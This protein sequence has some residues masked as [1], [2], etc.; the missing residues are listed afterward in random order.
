MAKRIDSIVAVTVAKYATMYIEAN[1]PEEAYQYAKEH[2][3]EV[4]DLDFYDSEIEVYSWED[5]VTE[6]DE[7]MNKIWVEDGE[8]MT[9]DEYMDELE[10]QEEDN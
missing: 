2:C 4:D 9:Y 1:T 8:T 6:A 3:G 7:F 10:A 5:Y